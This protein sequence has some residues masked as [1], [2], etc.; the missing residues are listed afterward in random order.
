MD[1][2]MSVRSSEAR[3]GTW[4]CPELESPAAEGQPQPL[5][6]TADAQAALE[7]SVFLNS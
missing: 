1:G 7:I 4:G 3:G 5:P 6:V 2:W